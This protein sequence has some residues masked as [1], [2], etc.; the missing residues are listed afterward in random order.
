M[1]SLVISALVGKPAWRER[2]ED[3]TDA[4]DQ[5]RDNLD[6]ERESPGPG[7]VDEPGTIGDPEGGDDAYYDAELL[8]HQK[9]T[10]DFSRRDLGDVRGYNSTQSV[11]KFKSAQYSV[12]PKYC[13]RG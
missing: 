9:G 12:V 6:Q 1:K 13:I 5:A 4:E 7:T 3:G 10:A 8:K 11:W 2:Q